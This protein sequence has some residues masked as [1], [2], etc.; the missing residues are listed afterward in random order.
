VITCHGR[1]LAW[2]SDS[3]TEMT[4]PVVEIKR[5]DGFDW[6]DAAIGAGGATGLLAISLPGAM[7]LRRRRTS[8]RSSTAVS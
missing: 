5:A 8:P 4:T 7:T 3:P 2:A 6:S 1:S